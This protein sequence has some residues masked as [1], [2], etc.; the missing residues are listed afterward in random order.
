MLILCSERCWILMPN[1]EPGAE[2]V[3]KCFAGSACLKDNT[4]LCN[5]HDNMNYELDLL[6]IIKES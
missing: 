1:N 2:V 4:C 5:S 3:L 6:N